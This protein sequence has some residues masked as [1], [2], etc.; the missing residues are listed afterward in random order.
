MVDAVTRIEAAIVIEAPTGTEVEAAI[1]V[2][3]GCKNRHNLVGLPKELLCP[4]RTGRLLLSK[5]F[6]LSKLS[7]KCSAPWNK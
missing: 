7:A 4:V 1:R 2:E 3:I 6:L 5:A